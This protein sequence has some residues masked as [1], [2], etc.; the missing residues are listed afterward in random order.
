MAQTYSG[1]FEQDDRSRGR[2][3]SEGLPSRRSACLL[4]ER[5]FCDPRR[6]IGINQ[7]AAITLTRQRNRAVIVRHTFRWNEVNTDPDRNP[8]RRDILIRC[9]S[10]EEILH[11]R[12]EYTEFLVAG[13]DSSCRAR[14]GRARS[15][16][17]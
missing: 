5:A 17:Q 10:Q 12:R 11:S 3:E 15:E 14:L 7:T 2:Y 1:D 9:Q 16:S 6:R 8:G 4:S 13:S